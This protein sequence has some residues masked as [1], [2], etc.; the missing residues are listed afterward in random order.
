LTRLLALLLAPMLLVSACVGVSCGC[1]TPITV[2]GAA[3]LASALEEIKSG[4][5]ESYGAPLY[6]TISTGASSALR[7]QIE[8]GARADVFLSADTSNPQALS[9]E[10][11]VDGAVVPFATNRLM[12][13][14][15]KGNPAQVSSPADLARAD[16]RVIAAG[17][18]VPI[19]KYATEAVT[20]LAGLPGYPAEFA[21]EYGSNIRSREENVG[22]VVAKIAL[23]E[24]DAAIVYASDA[25]T[26]D[27]D[28]I[29]IPVEANVVATYGGVVLK[30][31][32]GPRAAH[33]FLDWLR[34][35][36]G[37]RILA[38]AGFLPAP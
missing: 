10:G 4:F 1:V 25:R 8:Q 3:S 23:G 6:I 31:A 7:V 21:A 32:T 37:Q 9:D 12:I 22:A 14:V 28:A 19:S 17:E 35:T 26:P 24:G 5:S 38:E 15:P 13:I 18:E 27:V 33:A 11:L 20:K 2:L 16:V 36:D 34:G 30:S 29:E